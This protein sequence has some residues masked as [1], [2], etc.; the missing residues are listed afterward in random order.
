MNV[1]LFYSVLSIG[2]IGVLVLTAHT[3][4][5]S[6]PFD[7]DGNKER[8]KFSHKFH[9]ELTDCESCHSGAPKAENLS[10]RLLPTKDDCAACHDVKD[11]DACSKCHYENVYEPLVQEKTE[12]IFN[13]AFHKGLNISCTSCHLGLEK[14]DYSLESPNRNP[15]MKSCYSCH[16]ERKIATNACE[17]CHISTTNLIPKDHQKPNFRKVHK[18][19][20]SKADADCVMCHDNNSCSTCHGATTMLTE[21][22]TAKDFYQPYVPSNYIDGAKQQQ[23]TR[24]HDLNYRFTHGIELKGKTKEC[25]SC[26]QIEEFCVSCHTSTGGDILLGGAMPSSHLKPGFVT[27][28]KGSDGGEHAK[29]ARRDIERCISCH[30]VQGQDPTCIICHNEKIK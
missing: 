15:S 27:F 28:G 23:I 22:N 29:L 6:D 25:R 26:H 3:S 14:V 19:A 7:R 17:A 4:V 21:R 5:P 13:H 16:S 20:A 30:D 8:I 18:F 12:L 9:S 1:K 11:T 24:V 2:S 10:S